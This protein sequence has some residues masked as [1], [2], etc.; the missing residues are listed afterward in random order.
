MIGAVSSSINNQVKQEY[1]D[2]P[3]VYNEF[4]DIMANFKHQETEIPSVIPK[5]YSL[6]K[7]KDELILVSGDGGVC[8]NVTLPL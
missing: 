8:P 5:V 7:G 3:E 6:F 1:A 2:K 4:L